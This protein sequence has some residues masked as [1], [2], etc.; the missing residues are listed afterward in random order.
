MSFLIKIN[1]YKNG[2]L[3]S[4]TKRSNSS[5]INYID[6]NNITK[7]EFISDYINK[8]KPCIIKNVN[9]N[10]KANNEWNINALKKNYGE[11]LF[12]IGC[13]INTNEPI[14]MK[15][16]LFIEKYIN[17]VNKDNLYLFDPTFDFDCPNIVND[18]CV[19][20]I[21]E[22]DIISNIPDYLRPNYKWFLIGSSATG[23]K[24]H[25]DPLGTSAWNTLIVGK[26]EWIIFA[27]DYFND[28]N[29]IKLCIDNIKIDNFKEWINSF[30]L[31]IN[32]GDNIV[33]NNNNMIRFIQNENE[34]VFVP[35]GWFHLVINLETTVAVTHNFI[36]P[37][38]SINT[39]IFLDL[40][41]TNKEMTDEEYKLCINSVYNS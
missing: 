38:D 41:R 15:L 13:N 18:Y 26:K 37:S 24:F 32:T 34:T 28:N 29:H 31:I 25:T 12:Q 27:P 4:L 23:S 5:K 20:K 39:K 40:L 6:N 33:N 3:K 30:L 22:D 14:I 1:L 35:S 19:P 16:S 2:I 8:S 9:N 17:D 36:P 7:D 10:W 11:C 21:F